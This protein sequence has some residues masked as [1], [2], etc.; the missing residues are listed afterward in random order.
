MRRAPLAFVTILSTTLL[1]GLV[2]C[3]GSPQT[4][5]ARLYIQQ[6]DYPA[7]LAQ[8][9]AALAANPDDVEALTLK[10]DVLRMQ[11]ARTPNASERRPMIDELVNTLQRAQ[12]LAPDNA[13]LARTRLAA[14]GNEVN[15]G[16]QTLRAAGSD[17]AAV[18]NAVSA[19]E[20][21]V[22]LVPDSAAGHYNL[23]LAH[24]VAGH[25]DMAI[26]PLEAAIE[27]GIADENAYVYLSRAY[28]S[29]SRGADAVAMLERARTQFPDSQP[30]QAE[31]LNAYAATGQG[32]RALGAY[33]SAIAADPDNALLRYNYGSTLLQAQRYDEAIVQL[34]RAVALDNSNFNAHYNLGA[35]FQNQAAAVS[36]RLRDATN[37]ADANRLRGERDDLLRRALPH[38]VES[39]RLA[40]A[41]GEDQAEICR[42]LLSVY[43]TLGQTAEAREAGEC[44]G[45]DMN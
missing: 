34:E 8:L 41:S 38:F 6:E 30:I 19:F 20:N 45:I 11:A 32:D 7:A 42:A 22:M 25:H 15:V 37:D 18:A 31:L 26:G 2:G 39:R 5:S 27:R 29:A 36:E 40:G 28:L 16:G 43:T 9:N 33:E 44:A 13:E 21:A 17:Q 14:W 4:T 35:A 12:S 3:S 24:L 1:L 23:G 10:A